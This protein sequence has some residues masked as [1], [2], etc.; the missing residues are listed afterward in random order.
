ME[1]SEQVQLLQQE[2]ATLKNEINEIKDIL[3]CNTKEKAY[4][5]AQAAV[6]LGL[7]PCGI[8]YHI[9]KGSIRAL[10]RNKRNKKILESELN[11]Y[12]QSITKPEAKS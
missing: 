10:G 11:R 6:K 8:N 4:T 5:V 1:T 3:N 9:R 7:K 12:I 2:V